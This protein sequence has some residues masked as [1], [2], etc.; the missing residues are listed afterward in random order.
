M[1][2][3]EEPRKQG[4]QLNEP[5]EWERFGKSFPMNEFAMCFGA[6]KGGVHPGRST[7]GRSVNMRPLP[8]SVVQN[9]EGRAGEKDSW[10]GREGLRQRRQGIRQR[11]AG[12]WRTRRR[13]VVVVQGAVAVM[14]LALEGDTAGLKLHVRHAILLPRTRTLS[15]LKPT[16]PAHPLLLLPSTPH[17][18][19]LT[20][21]S[22]R[23]SRV[24]G[25]T[26]ALPLLPDEISSQVPTLP[27]NPLFVC[28]APSP[29]DTNARVRV[30]VYPYTAAPSSNDTAAVLDLC[31]SIPLSLQSA[32]T[33]AIYAPL[34]EVSPHLAV[35][36][37]HFIIRLTSLLDFAA[38]KVRDDIIRSSSGR[39]RDT[40]IPRLEEP[41]I[42]GAVTVTTFARFFELLICEM[43]STTTTRLEEPRICG[44]TSSTFVRLDEPQNCHQVLCP[45]PFLPLPTSS[46]RFLPIP[47]HPIP[48]LASTKSSVPTH[49]YLFLPLPAYPCLSQPLPTPSYPSLAFPKPPL[50]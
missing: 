49:S 18:R 41:Q 10:E 22:R 25:T 39:V 44:V 13:V 15:C 33:L 37:S 29:I 4:A 21:N 7:F 27:P 47:A 16:A 14:G 23:A 26:A 1:P 48:I 43:T 50:R 12:G 3:L 2:R 38:Y 6:R 28:Q 34:C 40:F 45:N 8:P 9:P 20:A 11:G 36:P 30:Y 42:Y 31:L 24:L 35:P 19:S 32:R 17:I 46:Y 5:Y